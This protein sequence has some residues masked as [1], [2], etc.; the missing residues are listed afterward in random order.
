MPNAMLA[1]SASPARKRQRLS[2][3]DY[4]VGSWEFDEDA[5]QEISRIELT[6][7]QLIR[8]QEE[9][10]P[11]SQSQRNA[12]EAKK[13]RLAAIKAALGEAT[14]GNDDGEEDAGSSSQLQPSPTEKRKREVEVEGG[15]DPLHEMQETTSQSVPKA[16]EEPRIL[17][18]SPDC[19]QDAENDYS[20]FFESADMSAL[21]GFQKLSKIVLDVTEEASS[22]AGLPGFAPAGKGEVVAGFAS[23][24]LGTQS[25]AWLEPSKEALELAARKMQDWSKDDEELHQQPVSDDTIVADTTAALMTSQSHAITRPVLASVSNSP[26]FTPPSFSRP[27]TPDTSKGKEKTNGFKSP[28]MGTSASR[29]LYPKAL[30]PG[31][32]NMPLHY[33]GASRDP[34]YIAKVGR[35]PH[36]LSS[37]P[38][39]APPDPSPASPGP[40]R[41]P[42][43][44]SFSTP[45]RSG[46]TFNTPGSV[47]SRRQIKTTFTT[48]FKPGMRPG[49]PGHATLQQQKPHPSPKSEPN[50]S[51]KSEGMLLLALLE[52]C[53]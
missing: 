23:A 52:C 13:R 20:K 33:P 6:L 36:P 15:T 46:T 37:T 38:I 31:V 11:S 4:E 9:Y 16:A 43:N 12:E 41:R 7:S 29:T 24:S 25:S 40:S 34:A 30:S 10:Q 1:P 21:P 49:E 14:E 18:P 8:N 27:V 35:I 51:R 39:T 5:I 42:T 32:Q 2:S 45:V 47:K 3:P 48:P 44:A 17:S 26:A 50:G 28:L 22:S 19:A 53:C